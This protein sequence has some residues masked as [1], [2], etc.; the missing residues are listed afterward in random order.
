MSLDAVT[1]Y[2][3][4]IMFTGNFCLRIV[5]SFL[6]LIVIWK[7]TDFFILLM[8]L[9]GI[10]RKRKRL[11]E[12]F[13]QVFLNFGATF[14]S[15]FMIVSGFKQ[16]FQQRKL[17]HDLCDAS[18][19]APTQIENSCHILCIS[20]ALQVSVVWLVLFTTCCKRYY[21]LFLVLVKC[22]KL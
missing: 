3:I 18:P 16:K 9:L 22:T 1:A 21:I 11:N 8:I 14:S 17:E 15:L 19:L 4:V 6:N 2:C 12:C 10:L 13:S 20:K 5:K 7:I